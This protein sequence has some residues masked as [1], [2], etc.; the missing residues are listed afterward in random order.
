MEAWG[1]MHMKN[2]YNGLKA[3]IFLTLAL[4]F[5]K[6]GLSIEVE[7]LKD[8][9]DRGEKVTIIDI[10]SQELFVEGHIR[11][12]INIPAAI[13]ARKP[14][15]PI[16]RVVVCGDGIRRDI[17]LTAVEALNARE[18]IQAEL[19]EGG[20]AAWQELSF[21]SARSSGV[22]MAQFRYITYKE[23]RKALAVN[24][25]MVLVDI[26]HMSNG[27]RKAVKDKQKADH[28]NLSDLYKKFPGIEIMTPDRSA[29][30]SGTENE[31]LSIAAFSDSER[32]GHGRVFVLVDRGDGKAEKVA[33][34]LNGAGIRQVVILIGGE[35][36]LQREGQSG[37]QTQVSGD[38]L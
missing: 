6:A 4:F 36:I 22:K 8:I 23:L 14:L 31:D 25:N 24:R 27:K 37:S 12:A 7:D 34:R 26:R 28:E 5:P 38:S 11:S 33:R 3:I 10:R 2:R 16:G 1:V 15:P 32:N 19:L 29:L 17:A 30:H 35:K 13:I 21:P 20:F 9:L 18:G